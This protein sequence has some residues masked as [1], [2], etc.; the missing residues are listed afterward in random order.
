MNHLCKTKLLLFLMLVFSWG[1]D[2]LAQEKTISGKVVEQQNGRP[3]SGVTVKVKNNTAAAITDE[4][5]GFQIKVPS[6]ESVITFSYVGYGIVELKAGSG[7]NL[8]VSLVQVNNSMDE[9]V[10][11]GYGTK[12]GPMYWAQSQPLNLKTLKTC[13]WPILALH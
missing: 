13:Q 1:A 8:S 6:A 12:N 4:N 9:V 10:V 3:I 2:A 7:A 11:V 5:G